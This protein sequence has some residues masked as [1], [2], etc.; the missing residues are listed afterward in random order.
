VVLD[1]SIQ[2]ATSGRHRELPVQQEKG[3]DV[4]KDRGVFEASVNGVGEAADLAGQGR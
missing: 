1:E 4:T 3:R 2:N